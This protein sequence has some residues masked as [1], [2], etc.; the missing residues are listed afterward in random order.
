MWHLVFKGIQKEVQEFIIEAEIEFLVCHRKA[1]RIWTGGAVDDLIENT[2][3]P[4]QLLDLRLVEMGY[5]LDVYTAIPK[6]NKKPL[7]HLCLVG[8]SCNNIIVPFSVKIYLD[9][10]H[11][12]LHVLAGRNLPPIGPRNSLLLL[13]PIFVLNSN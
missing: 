10:S 8:C 2:Q 3:I 9:H 6:F 13:R 12:L 1:V 7:Q 5:G 4:G 11:S